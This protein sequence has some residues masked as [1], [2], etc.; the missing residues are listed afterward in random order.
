MKKVL[1]PLPEVGFDVTEVAVPWRLLTRSGHEVVFATEHGGRAPTA[2]PLLLR[3]GWFFGP[4]GAATEARRAY[5]DLE[6]D[7]SF[8]NPIAWDAMA[9]TRADALLLP[10]GHAP[11]MKPYLESPVVQAEI[12]RRWSLAQPIA[13]IC[14][15]VVAVARSRDAAGVTLLRGRRTTALPAYMERTAFW[16]T[17]WRLGRHYRTYPEYVEAEVRRALGPGG[18]FE[19]GPRVLTTRGT[20]HDDRA[21]FVVEDGHYL[22]A[23]WPG[24]AYLFARRLIARLA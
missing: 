23:R 10:G 17:A 12:A 7:P 16:L 3:D 1:V 9:S 19:V 11:G 20:E 22:S 24:D 13:A 8:R 6:R 2:D 14:H 5:V 18:V 4:L 15:G 21:A